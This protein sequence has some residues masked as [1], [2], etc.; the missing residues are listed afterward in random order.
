MRVEPVRPMVAILPNGLQH[1]Q[2]SCGWDL[3]KNFHSALLAL[4]EAVLLYRIVG[5]AAFHFEPFAA[6]GIHDGLFGARLGRPA[7]LIRGEAQ[8]AVGDHDD[9]FWHGNIL[10]LGRARVYS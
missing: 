8:V 6:D 5:M 7:F 10:T 4:D 3:P 9:R 2:R 1:Y